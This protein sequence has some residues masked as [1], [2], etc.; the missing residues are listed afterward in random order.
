MY[1]VVVIGDCGF[2]WFV[3]WCGGVLL[4]YLIVVLVD[5]VYLGV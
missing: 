1:Y 3:G 4:G 5:L 2:G